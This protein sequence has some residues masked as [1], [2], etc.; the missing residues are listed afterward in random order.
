MKKNVIEN[1]HQLVRRLNK[2]DN[3]PE[4]LTFGVCKDFVRNFT[5]YFFTIIDKIT[6]PK[7]TIKN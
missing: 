2:I 4:D 6:V 1:L 7:K 3:E 5:D